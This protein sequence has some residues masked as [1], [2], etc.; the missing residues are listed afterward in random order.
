MEMYKFK[1]LLKLCLITRLKRGSKYTQYIF[2]IFRFCYCVLSKEVQYA[3][4]KRLT[5][6]SE[7]KNYFENKQTNKKPKPET[8]N[9]P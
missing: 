6:N 9:N 2:N 7:M 3:L 8:K 4:S 1:C 5:K